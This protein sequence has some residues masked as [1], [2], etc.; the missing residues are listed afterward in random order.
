MRTTILFLTFFF[1]DVSCFKNNDSVKVYN[2][3]KGLTLS[4][5]SSYWYLTRNNIGGGNVNLKISGSTN[6]AKVTVRT[7]GDGVIN[8]ENAELNSTKNF[9][10][11][12][13]ISFTATN[14]PSTEFEASTLIKAYK[15]TDTLV[16][17][18][19]SGELKY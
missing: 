4:I 9:N 5:T 1:A 12:I 19:K 10:D 13:V 2:D 6:G 8:D 15:G 3:T 14:V 16:V 18:L 11:D 7:Y 17:T